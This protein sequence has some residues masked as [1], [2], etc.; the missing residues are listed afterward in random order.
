MSQILHKCNI[1]DSIKNLVENEL[2]SIELIQNFCAAMSGTGS[3]GVR[4]ALL[5]QI[6]IKFRLLEMG[7][8]IS[9]YKPTTIKC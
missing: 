5:L 4:S 7:D 2:D 8:V 3:K 1:N 9:L 6:L